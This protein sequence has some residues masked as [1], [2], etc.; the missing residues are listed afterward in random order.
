MDEEPEG[1][2]EIRCDA[3]VDRLAA[4]G[5]SLEAFEEAASQ[6]FDERIAF[7]ESLGKDEDAGFIED[8][9]VGIGDRV[10][11]LEELAEVTVTGDLG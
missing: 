3:R 1:I 4:L 9:P 10:F 2:I 8:M 7:V 6:A 5:I 11:R